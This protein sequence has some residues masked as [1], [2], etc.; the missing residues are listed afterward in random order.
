MIE[1]HRLRASILCDACRFVAHDFWRVS[2]SFRLI[3][4]AQRHAS[5]R[6]LEQELLVQHRMV[7]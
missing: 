6:G 3:N 4:Q 5:T 7:L 2:Q 1:A